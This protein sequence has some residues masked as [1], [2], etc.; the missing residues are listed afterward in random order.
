MI[1]NSTITTVKGP[2]TV[3]TKTF[4]ET[5]LGSMTA[6][7]DQHALYFLQFTDSIIGE[8]QKAEFMDACLTPVE[9]LRTH[10]V[11]QLLQFELGAYF[12]GTLQEFT[13]PLFLDGTPFQQLAWKA[14]I[15][16]PYGRVRSYADQALAVGKPTAQ[17][18]VANA[19]SKNNIAIII[20]CHR[21]I[22]STGETGGYRG[23][24]ERKKWLLEHEIKNL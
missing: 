8:E 3:T 9:H 21:I 15:E 1:I 2:Q 16:V 19:N 17:R 18:A 7:F 23:S 4:I 6:L 24:L 11:F 14:L 5:P 12:T 20:P 13:I 10:T 22:K